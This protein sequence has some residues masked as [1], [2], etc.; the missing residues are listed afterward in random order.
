MKVIHSQLKK[1]WEMPKNK[2]EA[3]T[4]LFQTAILRFLYVSY[5]YTSFLKNKIISIDFVL[6]T[7][8]L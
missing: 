4:L 5:K 3:I 2:K 6:I 7:H 1:I 8:D